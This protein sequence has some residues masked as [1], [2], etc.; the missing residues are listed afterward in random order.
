MSDDLT[1]RG[2]PALLV[3]ECQLGVIDKDYSLFSG[4]VE[5]VQ[6]RGIVPRIAGLAQAFRAAGLPVIHAPVVHR[7]DLADIHANSLINALTLKN[8]KLLAGSPEAAFIPELRPEADDFVITRSA[9]LIVMNATSLDATL[10]RM[11]VE[12]LV[13]TGVSTNVAIAGNAMTA[14]DLGYH[15]VIPEDC[16]A[17][18]DAQTH[19]TL[20]KEQLRMLARI[21]S[22][23]AVSRAIATG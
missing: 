17:G 12:T 13:L 22:A 8:R 4:L 9:G 3:N 15:V 23:D 5:Q 18:A 10:R 16:I 2:R 14:I 11:G 20:V 7:T 19:E 21:T 1:L 6:T